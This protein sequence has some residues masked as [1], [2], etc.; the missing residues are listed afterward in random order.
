[1]AFSDQ[2]KTLQE[3]MQGFDINDLTADN[4]GTWPTIVKAVVWLLALVGILFAGYTFII[5]DM[6]LA[7][8]GAIAEEATLKKQF[9]DKAYQ[10]ANLQAYRKQMDEMKESF[11]ALISQLPSD[12]EVPGLLEDIS[13]R[14]AGSGLAFKN[15]ILQSEATRE[16]YIELPI[17]IVAT[18]TYHDMGAFVSGVASLPRIVTL[19]NFSITP[20]SGG[21]LTLDITA[22]TYR[23][24]DLAGAGVGKKK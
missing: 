9:E 18:G 16:F 2:I 4:I 23:Y 19:S 6:L 10:A 21:N 13:N 14:G 24:K 17:K 20:V 5:S 12:T 22:S 11:G 15:I 3:Q 7:Q 1:M 8:E